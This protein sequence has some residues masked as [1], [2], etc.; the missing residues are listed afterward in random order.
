M[1]T[2]SQHHT[3]WLDMRGTIVLGDTRDQQHVRLSLA[4]NDEAQAW[5]DA[6][7]DAEREAATRAVV[8]ALSEAGMRIK[9]ALLVA[10]SK[11][12]TNG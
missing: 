10:R 6:I 5:L 8:T 2:E 3:G 11:E 9:T 4:A 7:P 12:Q 1:A